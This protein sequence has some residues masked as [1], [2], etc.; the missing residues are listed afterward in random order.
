MFSEVVKNYLFHLKMAEKILGLVAPGS[1]LEVLREPKK[2]FTVLKGIIWQTFDCIL[3]YL[4]YKIDSI[5]TWFQNGVCQTPKI[6]LSFSTPSIIITARIFFDQRGSCWVVWFFIY[7]TQSTMNALM[8][9][10]VNT[11]THIRTKQSQL[12]PTKPSATLSNC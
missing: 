8:Y 4:N 1:T 2:T 5:M 6:Y 10:I 7:D 9:S 12:I 11:H 3:S